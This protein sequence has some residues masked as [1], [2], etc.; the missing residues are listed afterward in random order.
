[1]ASW[2]LSCSAQ[3]WSQTIRYPRDSSQATTVR[4]YQ[5]PVGSQPTT[6]ASASPHAA[7]QDVRSVNPLAVVRKWR[8]GARS[9]EPSSMAARGMA[10][11]VWLRLPTSIPT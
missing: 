4:P 6:V 3:F 7:N 11:T 8:T 9:Q 10:A 2:R 5:P 1:M